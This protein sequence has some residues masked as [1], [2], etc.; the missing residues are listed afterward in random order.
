MFLFFS[1]VK[2]EQGRK[3]IKTYKKCLHSRQ[4]ILTLML[5][6]TIN[7]LKIKIS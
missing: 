3:H 5:H 6:A 7:S 2:E 1:G 4:V